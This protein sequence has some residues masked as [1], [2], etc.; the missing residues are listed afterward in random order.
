MGGKN[1]IILIAGIILAVLAVEGILT[2]TSR[3]QKYNARTIHL[4][5]RQDGAEVHFSTRYPRAFVLRFQAPGQT[6]AEF[7]SIGDAFLGH[8]AD[9]ALSRTEEGQISLTDLP[10]RRV[11]FGLNKTTEPVQIPWINTRQS[12]AKHEAIPLDDSGLT[13]M[14]VDPAAQASTAAI[15]K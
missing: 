10:K 12:F 1:R 4:L 8:R 13:V 11:T 3:T 2:W 9:V 15:Q 14:F 7:H 5:S 6:A